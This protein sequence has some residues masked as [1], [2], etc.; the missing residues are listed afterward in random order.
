[1]MKNLFISNL[2]EKSHDKFTTDTGLLLRRK[3]D[4]SFKSLCKI[5][6]KANLIFLDNGRGLSDEEYF[7]KL[8]RNYIDPQSYDIKKNKNNIIVERY[9]ALKDK[10]PYI[11]VCNHSC[12]ED[13]ETVLNVIDRNTYLILGSIESLKYNPEMYLSFLNGMIPF[14][15]LDK[16][17]RKGLMLKMQRVVKTN[18]ILIFPEG[19]HNYSPNNLINPIYDGPVNLALK[20]GRKIVLVTM[21]KDKNISYVD[22]SNPIDVRDIKL[23]SHYNIDMCNQ[24]SYVNTLSLYI[25]DKMASAAY[26]IMERHIA[27]V[28][29]TNA[30]EENLRMAKIKDAFLK[31]K[32][33]KDVFDA[34]YLTKKTELDRVNE[35]VLNTVNSLIHKPH[36]LEPESKRY[37]LRKQIALDE[38]DVVIRMRRYLEENNTRA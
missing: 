17:Q 12:P 32:W 5:F 10:E 20:S 26:L 2:N 9:P 38:K 37:W 33:K 6:T 24:K 13:I 1:M 14:D 35:E 30:L 23:D 25:R 3:L 31:L 27:R 15:I 19:S 4:K 34:E 29:R 8:D 11:F 18:S 21:L 7:N 28:N 22:V 36:S 16:E